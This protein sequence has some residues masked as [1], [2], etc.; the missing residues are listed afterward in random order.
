VKHG[1]DSGGGSVRNSGGQLRQSEGS[2]NIS[3]EKSLTDARR[4]L[5]VRYDHP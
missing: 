5:K 2:A 4:R 3:G 1:F